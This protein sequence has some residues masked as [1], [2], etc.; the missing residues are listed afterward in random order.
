MGA[1]NPRQDGA[2][3]PRAVVGRERPPAPPARLASK[4]LIP[5]QSGL[6]GRVIRR[7]A[8]NVD[9]RAIIAGQIHR[10]CKRRRLQGSRGTRACHVGQCHGAGCQAEGADRPCRWRSEATPKL[11]AFPAL[12]PDN[13]HKPSRRW[14]F[15]TEPQTARVC[16]ERQ[17]RALSLEGAIPPPGPASPP[18]L[19]EQQEQ[20][21]A[22]KLEVKLGSAAGF[23]SSR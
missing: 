16:Q 2:A 22:G 15:G 10:G 18:V 14:L 9:F 21:A 3:R 23:N 11:G 8:D 12:R 19:A 4:L 13:S 6:V 7:T 5:A 20:E 17:L 1:A